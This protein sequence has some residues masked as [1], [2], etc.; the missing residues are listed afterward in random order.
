MNRCTHHQHALMEV[1]DNVSI[2][3][4]QSFDWND[5]EE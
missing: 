4:I 1:K 3:E 5:S 2:R